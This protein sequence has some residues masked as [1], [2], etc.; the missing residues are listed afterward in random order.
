MGV[1]DRCFT[2][3]KVLNPKSFAKVLKELQDANKI[4]MA[5]TIHDDPMITIIDKSAM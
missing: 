1:D 2:C 4:R 3:V 5:D